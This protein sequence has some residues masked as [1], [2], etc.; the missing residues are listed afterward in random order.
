MSVK[1]PSMAGVRAIE[2]TAVADKI[3]AKSRELA[4]CRAENDRLRKDRQ[5]WRSR[6]GLKVT[7][8]VVVEN[9][10]LRGSLQAE[11]E[12]NAH[13]CK[14]LAENERLREFIRK[15]ALDKGVPMS[16]VDAALKEQP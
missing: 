5:H 11:R 3:D 1:D 12:I 9:E 13:A 16:I 6:M 15:S 7:D 4:A 8:D 2:A 10:R 14:T